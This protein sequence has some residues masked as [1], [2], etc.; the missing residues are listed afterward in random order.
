MSD[1]AELLHRKMVRIPQALWDC[2]VTAPIVTV[3]NKVDRLGEGE[4]LM[5][6]S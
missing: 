3:L 2:Q 5:R 6:K 4:A 1:P